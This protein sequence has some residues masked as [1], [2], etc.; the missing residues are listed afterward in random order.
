MLAH[1]DGTKTMLCFGLGKGPHARRL[2]QLHF[3]DT[4]PTI[5]LVTL[6]PPPPPPPPYIT[7]PT[8]Q[9]PPSNNPS[10]EK[11]KSSNAIPGPGIRPMNTLSSTTAPTYSL[12][13]N[14]PQQHTFGT[15][16]PMSSNLAAQANAYYQ[17]QALS[18]A[19]ALGGLAQPQFNQQAQA[20]QAGPQ[21]GLHP[22]VDNKFVD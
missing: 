17:A 7:M 3:K 6:P 4:L 22:R 12:A 14:A 19:R 11:K 2:T 13:D 16:S 5:L 15:A 8:E 9:R 1:P 20:S 10:G 21:R 18:M